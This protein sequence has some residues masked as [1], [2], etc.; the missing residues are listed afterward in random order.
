[1][2]YEAV[3]RSSEKRLTAG[4]S[5]RQVGICVDAVIAMAAP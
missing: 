1:M 5:G 3:C 2:E 4:L